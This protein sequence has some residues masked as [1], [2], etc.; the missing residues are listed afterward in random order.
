MRT[1]ESAA[2]RAQATSSLLRGAAQTAELLQQQKDTTAA[3]ENKLALQVQQCETLRAQ[4]RS[5]GDGTARTDRS[6][7]AV[8]NERLRGINEKLR[9]R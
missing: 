8:A 3:L 6:D 5:N 1:D 2:A 4:L 9:S 7:D